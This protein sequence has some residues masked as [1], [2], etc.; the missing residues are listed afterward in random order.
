MQ[1]ALQIKNAKPPETQ[2]PLLPFEK[3]RSESWHTLCGIIEKNAF[4]HKNYYS[5]S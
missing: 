2:P 3:S 1:K 5:T 4:L